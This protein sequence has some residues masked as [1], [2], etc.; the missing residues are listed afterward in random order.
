M[1]QTMLCLALAFCFSPLTAE[2]DQY[3]DAD[4]MIAKGHFSR[5]VASY[6]A[7]K[8]QEALEEFEA[9]WRERKLADLKYWIGLCYLK[10]GRDEEALANLEV[11]ANISINDRKAKEA[12][13]LAAGLRRKL[14]AKDRAL[15]SSTSPPSVAPS[16]VAPS[17]TTIT[18]RVP[19]PW[20]TKADSRI[21]FAVSAALAV[22]IGFTASGLE[23]SIALGRGQLNE[24]CARPCMDPL[25][26]DLRN[27]A[28]GADTMWIVAGI[29]GATALGFGIYWGVESRR[30]RPLK[31]SFTPTLGGGQFTLDF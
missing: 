20:L 25:L 17:P 10:L 8:H 29:T 1:R 30:E 22:A 28:M 24:T 26:G 11:Y 13:G 6:E 14:E 23:L 3:P 19:S 4:T 2:A 7:G 12:R 16:S 5:G 27:Q 21:V 15:S 31:A 9:A 18:P